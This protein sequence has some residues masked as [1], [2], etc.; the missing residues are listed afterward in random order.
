M[1]KGGEDVEAEQREAEGAPPMMHPEGTMNN[2]HG[3]WRHTRQLLAVNSC[4]Y[5]YALYFGLQI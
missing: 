2:R 1:H 4:W 3:I 5:L